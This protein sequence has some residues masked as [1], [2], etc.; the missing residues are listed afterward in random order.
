MIVFILDLEF[1]PVALRQTEISVQNA[2]SGFRSIPVNLN[3]AAIM[4]RAIEA[5]REPFFITL[6]A[7]E[8]LE[9]G[10]HSELQDWFKELPDDCAGICLQPS[11]PTSDVLP[12]SSIAPRGPVVWRREAVAGMIGETGED[13]GKPDASGSFL[14]SVNLPFEQYVL[15]EMMYRLS[16][17]WTWREYRTQSWKARYFSS[18]PGWRKSKEEWSCI[19]PIISSIPRTVSVTAIPIITVVVCTFD[20]AEYLPWSIRSML[21]QSF[22]DWELIVIDDGSQDD[23][24]E[25]L[26][27]YAIDPR[28]IL[29]RNEE[30]RGKAFC[31]N[32]ALSLAR[33]KWLLELDADDWLT[34][35]CLEVIAE[36]AL[37]SDDIGA[38]YAHHYEWLERS[39]KQLL[40][41]RIELPLPEITPERLL[42]SASPLAPRSYRIRILKELGGWWEHDPYQGRLYEDVQL[43][44]RISSRYTV[45]HI[46]KALYHRRIRNASITRRNQGNYERWAG[47]MRRELLRA[48]NIEVN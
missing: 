46:R 30:N 14:T 12:L 23:T 29:I 27:P 20:N 32:K 21:I 2:F 10:F 17:A 40:F 41:K 44:I 15:L 34:P 8:Q 9:H 33:G 31:L 37:T 26:Q 1:N 47:W 39:N 35:D 45:K 36:Q 48:E 22:T 19:H 16:S 13:I 18:S 4:N 5:S 24:G 7:G 6:Y 42:S 28:V 43:L 25:K 38:F 11:E 3:F